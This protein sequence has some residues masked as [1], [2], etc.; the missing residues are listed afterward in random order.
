MHRFGTNSKN[1]EDFREEHKISLKKM[2]VTGKKVKKAKTNLLTNS[3]ECLETVWKHTFLYGLNSTISSE[4][5]DSPFCVLSQIGFLNQM[6]TIK[7]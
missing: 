4:G 7:F 6:I 5:Y 2:W 1:L 3:E